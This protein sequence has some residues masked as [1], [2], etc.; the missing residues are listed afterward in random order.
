MS[1]GVLEPLAVGVALPLLNFTLRS[2]GRVALPMLQDTFEQSAV[3]LK[4]VL[5]LES[6]SMIADDDDIMQRT[7]QALERTR[8][9]QRLRRMTESKLNL[10]LLKQRQ[11]DKLT[12]EQANEAYWAQECVK[13]EAQEVAIKQEEEVSQQKKAILQ[14]EF[15]NTN[16]TFTELSGVFQQEQVTYEML[17]KQEEKLI[18]QSIAVTNEI[19]ELEN[20]LKIAKQRLLTVNIEKDRTSFQL[21]GAQN[22]VL[23]LR[24]NVERVTSIKNIAENDLQT[25]VTRFQ[26]VQSKKNLINLNKQ[27][28][29]KSLQT[30]RQSVSQVT[31]KLEKLLEQTEMLVSSLEKEEVRLRAIDKLQVERDKERREEMLLGDGS[32]NRQQ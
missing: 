10:D 14:N 3:F 1:S 6:Q 9:T 13:L 20:A 18:S 7:A 26:N 15:F 22:R 30:S 8:V 19:L 32:T 21:Q 31:K 17:V 4:T 11:L 16:A 29:L 5:D 24:K 25:A 2:I 12:S 28:S 27:N 23:E